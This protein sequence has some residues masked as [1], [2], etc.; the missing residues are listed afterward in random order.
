MA[1]KLYW[2]IKMYGTYTEMTGTT[3]EISGTV[4]KKQS[5]Q[6]FIDPLTKKIHK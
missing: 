4:E 6:G 3:M 1:H 2:D 5:L